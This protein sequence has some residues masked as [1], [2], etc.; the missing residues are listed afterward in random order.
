MCKHDAI[1]RITVPHEKSLMAHADPTHKK[2]FNEESFKY[3]CLNGE[4]YWIHKLYGIRCKFILLDQEICTEKRF[5]Y[6]KVTLKAVKNDDGEGA[7]KYN[8]YRETLL[9][10]FKNKIK[11]AKLT[12]R[13]YLKSRIPRY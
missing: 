8:E 1:V 2:V 12:L 10:K 6:I 3:F 4:H 7:Y 13:H 9:K 11:C 5:G